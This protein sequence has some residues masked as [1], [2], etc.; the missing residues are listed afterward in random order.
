[1]EIAFV[2]RTDIYRQPAIRGDQRVDAIFQIDKKRSQLDRPRFCRLRKKSAINE[3][4]FLS[5]RRWSA[6]RV[7]LLGATRSACIHAVVFYPIGAKYPLG[8]DTS[9]VG[10]GSHRLL[11]N[12]IEEKFK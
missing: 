6:V 1:L 5:S 7:H 11:V 8:V 3:N 12:V 4:S 10:R 9:T 2:S